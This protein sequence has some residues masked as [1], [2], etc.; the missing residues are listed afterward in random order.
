MSKPLLIIAEESEES[1]NIVLPINKIIRHPDF[2][3][4]RGNNTSQ[5]V[6]NDIAVIFVNDQELRDSS[7]S[8]KI[9]PACLPTASTSALLNQK[10]VHSGWSYPPSVSYVSQFVEP[11]LPLLREFQK[12]WHHSMNIAP[13]SDPT[14]VNN[15]DQAK[16]LM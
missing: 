4:V 14:V 10:A 13:C 12:Q 7:F 16:K 2:V 11:Y 9:N 8:D 6:E 5:F 3:I 15:N 1:F